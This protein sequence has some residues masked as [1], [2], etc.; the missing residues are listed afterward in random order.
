MSV[1]LDGSKNDQVSIDAIPNYKMP[2]RFVEDEFKLLNTDE[3]D[4]ED[5]SEN[6]ENNKFDLLIDQEISLDTINC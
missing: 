2:Q 6:N 4:D 3:D 5:A 1:A